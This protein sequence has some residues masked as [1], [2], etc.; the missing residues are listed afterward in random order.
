MAENNA[1]VATQQAQI[2]EAQLEEKKNALL[3]LLEKLLKLWEKFRRPKP[4]EVMK[5]I[6]DAMEDITVANGAT[7]AVLEDLVQITNDLEGRMNGN[8]TLEELE[9]F[10]DN[11]QE[12][13]ETLRNAVLGIEKAVKFTNIDEVALYAEEA[14]GELALY[15]DNDNLYLCIEKNGILARQFAINDE[16]DGKSVKVR[17]D[18][19]FSMEELEKVPVPQI[20]GETKRDTIEGIVFNQLLTKDNYK[21]I[22]D[23]INNLKSKEASLKGQ[24]EDAVQ[25]LNFFYKYAEKQTSEDGK[26]IAF[27]EDNKTFN[28]C[29]TASQKM[30]TF[31]ASTNEI[32]LSIS[33]YDENFKPTITQNIGAWSFDKKTGVVHHIINKDKGGIIDSI[34]KSNVAQEYLR[35]GT[36][37]DEKL[38]KSMNSLLEDRAIE[39]KESE[40]SKYTEKL[41][42]KAYA[43]KLNEDFKANG[44]TS[45][46]TYHEK[47]NRVVIINAENNLAVA[48]G[49]KNGKPWVSATDITQKDQNGQKISKWV[50]NAKDAIKYI[51]VRE[52]AEIAA[53]YKGFTLK[54]KE[55]KKK[56]AETKEPV[57]KDNE[58]NEGG[59]SVLD[60]NNVSVVTLTNQIILSNVGKRD[61]GNVNCSFTNDSKVISLTYKD[62]EAKLNFIFDENDKPSRVECVG[63][64]GKREIGRFSENGQIIFSNSAS[65]N[66]RKDPFIASSIVLVTESYA[67]AEKYLNTIENNKEGSQKSTTVAETALSRVAADYKNSL[68]VAANNLK[69]AISKE[70]F[71][72][73][74]SRTESRLNELAVIDGNGNRS[75]T[76]LEYTMMES[77]VDIVKRSASGLD[78]NTDEGKTAFDSNIN[79]DIERSAASFDSKMQ[80]NNHSVQ[81]D[82]NNDPAKNT[83]AN[84][85]EVDR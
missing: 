76:Q 78:L 12:R 43:D 33:N 38:I 14:G 26:Y 9:S 2:T 68:I 8:L 47:Q 7:V 57:G 48:L 81:Q 46:A 62:S 77:A 42:L 70:G 50:N 84:K 17:F 82:K 37:F 79:A 36:G 41:S 21:N 72:N 69:E 63:S 65:V 40:N 16:Y 60:S 51:P 5:K 49:E 66:D 18:E 83:K 75:F 15:K 67:Q 35:N 39:R 27:R 13:I 52:L 25:K 56:V 59:A 55:T 11:C 28:I 45:V 32:Q 80:R 20:S 34:L 85:K 54:D 61:I 71:D 24:K 64:D 19:N 4:W 6:S 53:D 29:D 30:L 23:T 3:A 74:I 73:A 22:S 44:N 31:E 10:T 58:A 1:T